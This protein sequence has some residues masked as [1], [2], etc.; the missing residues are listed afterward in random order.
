VFAGGAGAVLSHLS[1]AALWRLLRFVPRLHDVI[2]R[3]RHR[4][5]DGIHFR[6]CLHLHPL[7]AMKYRGIPVTTVARTLVDLTDDLTAEELTNVIH[8]A[9][10]RRRFS[11]TATKQTMKRANGRHNLDRLEEAI[12]AHLNHSA[13]LRSRDEKT[14]LKLFEAHGVPK[15]LVNTELLGIEVDF[16]WPDLKLVAEVDGPGHA[17]PRTQRE[18]RAVD[19][20]LHAAGYTTVRLS[21]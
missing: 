18:D 17:R 14:F 7:D 11:L 1:A 20:L 16:H 6:T 19:A 5:V 10:Y 3:R 21:M 9:A 8:E 15:P 4:P 12:Q 13:G 2:V